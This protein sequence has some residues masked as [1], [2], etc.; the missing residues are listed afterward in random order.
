MSKYDKST[1]NEI[2][3]F[4]TANKY[5]NEY[6][7]KIDYYDDS[8]KHHIITIIKE[9]SGVK[10]PPFNLPKNKNV[11]VTDEIVLDYNIDNTIV[12]LLSKI[13]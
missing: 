7:T 8:L 9:M 2:L 13:Y 10:L 6:N 5:I 12:K 1:D 4:I 11:K 3:K